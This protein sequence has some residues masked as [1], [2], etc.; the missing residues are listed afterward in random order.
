MSFLL[1]LV[2]AFLI[3]GLLGVAGGKL[4]K[5]F[6]EKNPDSSPIGILIATIVAI[7]VVFLILGAYFQA[8]VHANDV[9]PVWDLWTTFIN[10]IKE[11]LN[12][13]QGFIPNGVVAQVHMVGRAFFG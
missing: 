13:P 4:I 10:K 11:G 9:N 2:A 5:S 3:I 8:P 7:L 6:Q 12:N 1:G